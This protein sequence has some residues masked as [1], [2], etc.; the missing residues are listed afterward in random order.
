MSICDDWIQNISCILPEQ[1]TTLDLVKV[2]IYTSPHS[3]CAARKIGKCP[4]YFKFGSRIMYPR[5]GVVNW[6]M[7][8]KH[9]GKKAHC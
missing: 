9:E 2:G 3:A 4:P 6:L 8:Q 5:A 1:C 7:D